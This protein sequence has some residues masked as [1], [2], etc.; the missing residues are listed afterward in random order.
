MDKLNTK[1]GDNGTS[2]FGKKR[3]PKCHRLFHIVGEID[4]LNAQIGLCKKHDMFIPNN[5]LQEINRN[6]M[7]CLHMG[8]SPDESILQKID[9]N[10]ETCTTYLDSGDRVISGWMNYNNQWGIVC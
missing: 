9:D 7:G 8:V 10:L 1:T 3:L 2:Q 6:I 4:M 5:D